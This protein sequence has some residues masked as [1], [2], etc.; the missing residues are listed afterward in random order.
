MAENCLNVFL[1]ALVPE[2]FKYFRY[3]KGHHYYFSIEQEK[4]Y[5]RN[6]YLM[7]VN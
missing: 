3:F 4:N 1:F 7:H 5:N 6:I 2:K